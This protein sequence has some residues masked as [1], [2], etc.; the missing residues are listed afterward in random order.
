MRKGYKIKRYNRIYRRRPGGL[1]PV[2]IV[3]LV[4]AAALSAL[5]VFSLYG[6]VHDFLSGRLSSTIGA[7][8]GEEAADV[9]KRQG[10]RS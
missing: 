3:L 9:Y 5:L 10:C 4:L 6:P 8:G 7:S 2:K 1:T